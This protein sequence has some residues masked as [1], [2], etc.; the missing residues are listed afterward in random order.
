MKHFF[1][2][3]VSLMVEKVALRPKLF[4]CKIGKNI[5]VLFSL[6]IFQMFYFKVLWF[7]NSLGD[8][9]DPAQDRRTQNML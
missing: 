9:G 7:T 5:C 3:K 8:F 1:S 6:Q 4:F 2:V